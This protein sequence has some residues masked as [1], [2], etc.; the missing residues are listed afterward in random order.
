MRPGKRCP[1]W[2]SQR[3]NEISF[4]RM[5]PRGNNEMS[6]SNV[7]GGLRSEAGAWGRGGQMV[8]RWQHLSGRRTSNCPGA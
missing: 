2:L 8:T 4:I 1:G 6:G 5:E 7:C 3:E